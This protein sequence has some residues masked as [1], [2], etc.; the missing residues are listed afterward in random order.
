MRN[1][2]EYVLSAQMAVFMYAYV[3]FPAS[4]IECQVNRHVR[5]FPVPAPIYVLYLAE[6]AAP[7]LGVTD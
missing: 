4:T 7:S 5:R 6:A 2:F 3:G 1:S